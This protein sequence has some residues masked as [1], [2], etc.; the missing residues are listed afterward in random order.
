MRLTNNHERGEKMKIVQLE[1][2]NVKR[3]KAVEIRPD[4]NVIVIGG[5]NGAGKSSV[6]DS[7]TYALAG[8]GSIPSQPVRNGEKKAKIVCELDN[9]TIKRTMTANGGGTLTVENKEG[10]VFK[11]PQAILDALT[12][13][14]TF[15]PLA[16]SN[17]DA[18]K[19][20]ETLKGLVG[21]DFSELDSNRQ[22]LYEERSAVNTSGKSLKA[23]FE[24]MQEYPDAP[25]EEVSV[26]DLMAELQK[27]EDVNKENDRKRDLL[28]EN[29]DDLEEEKREVIRIDKEIVEAERRLEILVQSK[30]KI[31][32]KIVKW[33]KDIG[34]MKSK[35]KTLKDANETEIRDQIANAETVNQQ[36]R[37]NQARGELSEELK[38]KRKE[39][40]SLTEQIHEIDESKT[41]QLSEAKFPVSGLSFSEADVL[42]NDIPFDQASSAEQLSV[43]VAMGL[44]MNPKLKVLLIRD[45][46]LLDED[47]LG[48][49]A[50]MAKEA[51][52]QVW[53]ERVSK[54]DECQVIIEDG[55]IR[56]E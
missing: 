3:L 39:S 54:G 20:V 22:S 41:K 43:S 16:F 32:N 37:S 18:R 7:I 6:L 28:G 21:L 24:G 29:L 45:G 11:S 42:Y 19:Q 47:N 9:L 51:D 30:T 38:T 4:G 31:I 12:G 14:L 2:Q 35:V 40:E 5:K 46:S 53:I 17:M 1:A 26:S 8:K 36:V 13:K 10:A 15:D 34:K 50:G 25:E 56:G 44:A 52:A 55:E 23:R 33:E 48:L 27:R 49:I